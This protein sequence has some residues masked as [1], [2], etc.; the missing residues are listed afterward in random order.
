MRHKPSSTK[1]GKSRIVESNGKTL[2]EAIKQK[3]LNMSNESEALPSVKSLADT[4]T[5]EDKLFHDGYVKGISEFIKE[6]A[7]PMTI[8]IQGDW[9]TGKT[10]LINLIEAELQARIKITD[11]GS[12]KKKYCKEI[13]GVGVF[14]AWKHSIT[15]PSADLFKTL[16]AEMV[17]ILAGEDIEA[18]EQVAEFANAASRIVGAAVNYGGDSDGEAEGAVQEG[19]S[20]SE[21]EEDSPLGLVLRSLFGSENDVV[22]ETE[23]GYLASKDIQALKTAFIYALQ[24][25]AEEGGKSKDSRFVVFVDGLDHIDPVDAIEL[26]EHAKYYLN[27]SGCV[28]VYAVDERTVYDGIRKKFGDKVNEKRKKMFFEKLVQVPLRIPVSAY[29]LNKYVKDLLKD[30]KEL[31]GELAKVI[32]TLLDDP[33]P[34]RIKRYINTMYLYQSIFGGSES[35]GEDSLAMLLAAVILEIESKQGFSAIDSCVQGDKGH[36]SENLNATLDS[37]SDDDGINW[38]LLPTLW[39]G[40]GG[41]DLD[42]KKR[43]AFRSWV[44]KLR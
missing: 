12:Q 21:Y 16:L 35:A 27:C 38:A 41:A 31:S 26:M 17:Q 3:G 28:F 15:N 32:E 4:A 6:C 7:T 22:T 5:D 30:E 29:N 40:G 42:V 14:D 20:G 8:A 34:Q 19:A 23:G 44:S 43:R 39:N 9:G 11:D 2:A 37:L 36:F 33:T 18:M 24:K 1:K 13:I 10:S 25:R